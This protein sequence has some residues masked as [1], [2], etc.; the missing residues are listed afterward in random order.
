[1]TA[2]TF[3][4]KD[5]RQ[6]LVTSIGVVLGFLIGFLGQWVTEDDFA[7]RTLSDTVVLLGCAGGSLLLFGSLFRL[8]TPGVPPEQALAHY[9]GTLRL[10]LAGI[11]SALGSVLVSAFV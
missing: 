1:M 4:L 8:L 7:L 10:T 5:F 6:P 2:P 9:R 11:A 3:D